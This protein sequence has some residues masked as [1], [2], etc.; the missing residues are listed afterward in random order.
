MTGGVPVGREPFSLGICAT[1]CLFDDPYAC[2][3]QGGPCSTFP[4]VDIDKSVTPINGFGLNP[5]SN[6]G[7]GVVYPA[8][9]VLIKMKNHA[10]TVKQLFLEEDLLAYFGSAYVDTISAPQIVFSNSS[11]DPDIDPYF[12]GRNY[13]NI[14]IPGSGFLSA[15]QEIW[16]SFSVYLDPNAPGAYSNLVNSVYGGG[17]A[18][19][20]Y[21]YQDLSGDLPSGFGAPTPFTNLPAGYVAVLAQ[22]LTLEATVPNSMNGIDDWLANNGWAQF[23]VPGCD[24]VTWTNDYDPANWVTGCGQLTG[25]IE[26][27]FTATDNCGHVFSTCATF[28]LEDTVGPACTKP[29]DLVL[30]CGDPNA[31]HTLEEWLEYDGTFTDLS[32]PVIFTNDFAGLD[33]LGCDGD[34]ILVTWTATDACGNESYFDAFLSV[35]DTTAPIISGVPDDLDL[36][37]CDS[38]PV[39]A[40]ASVSDGCDAD[41]ELVFEE[42]STGDSCHFT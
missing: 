25:Y 11:G 38:I 13:T 22:D 5:C 18:N 37:K 19:G 26:V 10:G 29:E 36:D 35:T 24:P 28:T 2:S 31:I 21:I 14:F 32:T 16:V 42:T 41:P 1:R 4:M 40:M 3:V 9:E 27:T 12:D 6:P 8:F 15:G 23:S 39:P 17:M 33:S 30:D 7:G 20:S 34:S